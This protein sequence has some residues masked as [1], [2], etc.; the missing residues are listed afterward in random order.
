MSYSY[1]R[2]GFN[3]G[4]ERNERCKA[5]SLPP[6]ANNAAL[7]RGQDTLERSGVG[8]Y[9]YELVGSDDSAVTGVLF[10]GGSEVGRTDE[11]DWGRVIAQ[12]HGLMMYHAAG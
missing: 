4:N 11:D 3:W 5:A 10:C 1:D 8:A 7:F 2:S 12:L 9:E 6:D